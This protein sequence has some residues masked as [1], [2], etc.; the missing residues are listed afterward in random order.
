M[1]A[2]GSRVQVMSEVT[3][4]HNS[5]NAAVDSIEPGDT[6]TSYAELSRSLRSIAQSLKLPLAVE[7]YSDMQQTGWPANFNDLRLSA[8]VQLNPHAIEAKETPNFTVENVVA[9]RRVYD[10][11]KARVLATVA[12]FGNKKSTRSVSLVLNGR[13]LET[14]Q[15]EV[16]E[17]GRATVEFLS[18]DVPYGR[19]KGEVRIDTADTLPADDTF[20]FSVERSDPRHALFVQESAGSRGLLFFKAALDAAG[21]SAFEIDPATVDQVANVSPSKYAFVVLSDLGAVPPTFENALR[22]YVRGG[23]SVL[24]RA[25]TPLRGPQQRAGHRR[26]HSGG[27]LRRPRGRALP[28]RGLARF[29]ASFD[30]EGRP[31]GRRQVL[32]GDSRGSGQLRAWRPGSATRRRCCSISN[33]AKATCWSSRPPSTTWPTIFRSTPPSCRSSSRRRATWDASMPARPSV[34]V[35]GFAELR[36]SKEKGAAVEVLDPKGERALS[37]EEATKAQNIQFTMAGFYDI[38]RPNGRNELVAVNADRHESDLA[39]VTAGQ[40]HVVAEY[41]PRCRRAG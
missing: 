34:L 25:R 40:S 32:P 33:W 14:K 27:A 9:P 10:A 12:G 13:V 21:Q 19:N 8:A 20:Y 6:R 39:P 37:L 29:L 4:D 7:L 36:D 1:L 17:N 30:P 26:R 31:L 16:P 38:R 18:L 11:K 3:D 2:F 41:G 28:D 24:D 35:G 15:V 23:G 5:L 22:D